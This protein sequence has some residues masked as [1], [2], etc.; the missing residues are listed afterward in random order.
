[1]ILLEYESNKILEYLMI[2][3]EYESN[4]IYIFIGMVEMNFT[5]IKLNVTFIK[6]TN[7]LMLS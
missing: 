7:S 6:S 3:L 4:K 1:M 5:P 2:P